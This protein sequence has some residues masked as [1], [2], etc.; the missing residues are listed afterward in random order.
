M[1]NNE[2]IITKEEAE[3]RDLPTSIN[4]LLLKIHENG[5]G[6]DEF[7]DQDIR[8][9]G[10]EFYN[11]EL[12][13]I[14]KVLCEQLVLGNVAIFNAFNYL[15]TNLDPTFLTHFWNSIGLNNLEWPTLFHDITGTNNWA[16][17]IAPDAIAYFAL[18]VPI[19]KG[20]AEVETYTYKTG[21]W[22]NIFLGQG[23]AVVESARLNISTFIFGPD[24]KTY[25][26]QIFKILYDMNKERIGIY[27]LYEPVNWRNLGMVIPIYSKDLKTDEDLIHLY[28][29]KM[30][31]GDI[32]NPEGLYMYDTL[33]PSNSEKLKLQISF[34]QAL[35]L[36]QHQFIDNYSIYLILTL[37][38]SWNMKKENLMNAAKKEKD[39]FYMYYHYYTFFHYKPVK[40][41]TYENY[42]EEVQMEHQVLEKYSEKNTVLCSGPIFVGFLVEIDFNG[43]VIPFNK[44]NF[45]RTGIKLIFDK[46]SI[47]QSTLTSI[48]VYLKTNGW[49][50][51]GESDGFI[52][53]NPYKIQGKNS[54]WE[55]QM[56][57]NENGMPIGFYFLNLPGAAGHDFYN[58]LTCSGPLT[59]I[60]IEKNEEGK[61]VPVDT[62]NEAKKVS[63]AKK[64]EKTITP[65]K[66]VEG[67]KKSRRRRN[68]KGKYT[69]RRTIRS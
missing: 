17:A 15:G 22:L 64:N 31:D 4:E 42:E 13:V 61:L 55:P 21:S 45:I 37:L 48:P 3:K 2:A 16:M 20:F 65:N 25:L 6:L 27:D 50:T 54:C 69:T 47:P 66:V 41:N 56:H 11:V 10:K 8:Y 1:N 7:S 67:G 49:F 14:N 19:F 58:L 62:S 5:N 60:V 36:L 33:I 12:W 35:S 18:Y 59:E 29:I 39:G 68:K 26:L 44:E 32:L 34:W 9:F 30:Y 23:Y 53:C 63:K 51:T 43:N 24:R 40:E 38:S 28:K 46:D 57:Y 52:N